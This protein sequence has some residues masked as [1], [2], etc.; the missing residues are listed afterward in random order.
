MLEPRMLKLN[1][2][3]NGGNNVRNVNI[4][5]SGIVHVHSNNNNKQSLSPKILGSVMNSQQIS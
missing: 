5:L 4:I 1:G 3:F 2:K